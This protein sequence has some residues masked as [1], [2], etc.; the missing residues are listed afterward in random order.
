[1]NPGIA[2][3]A[4]AYLLWGLFP[5]YFKQLTEVPAL[6]VI[7]H[8]TLWSL[9]FV[10]LLMTVLR[11][12]AWAPAV[13]RKPRLLGLF[14]LSASLLVVNSLAYVW[15]VQQGHVLEASL[16][17]FINP[18]VNVALGFVF[19]R[20]RPRPLQWAAVG[21]ATAGVLW[22]TVQ[23]GR[24]PWIAL[25]I[26]LSFGFYGLVRKTAPL[27]AMEGLTLETLLVAPVA[28]GALALWT[29]QGHSAFV[30]GTSAQ[31][32]WLLLAGPVT[33]IPLLL[34]AAG[35]RRLPL[36]TLGLIQ[37]ISPSMQFLLGVFLFR[38]PLEPARLTA[39]A[40]IW[41][42][43]AIYSLEGLWRGRR[44]AALSAV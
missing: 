14:G 18:L 7:A 38:E 3:A 42:A 23:T 34:F 29:A 6:E 24:A 2:Y 12:W 17:Y 41:A 13:L 9:A 27:G 5:L 1:M 31:L 15:A 19:L 36:T 25:V 35:A 16:G 10:A 32:G 39:F 40:C 43:L 33:A 28:A 30:A 44:A 22:M 21:L 11:R 8:R 4:L 26:A 20:E 37:Y